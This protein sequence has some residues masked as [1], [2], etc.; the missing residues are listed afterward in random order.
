[1]KIHDSH[2]MVFGF[3][4]VA[5]KTFLRYFLIHVCTF[6]PLRPKCFLKEWSGDHFYLSPKLLFKNADSWAP[7]QIKSISGGQYFRQLPWE[8]CHNIKI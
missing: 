1:M 8:G 4:V 6:L 2:K 5:G 7:C 3:R